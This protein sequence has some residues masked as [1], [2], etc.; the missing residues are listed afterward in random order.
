MSWDNKMMA[1]LGRIDVSESDEEQDDEDEDDAYM[2]D[3]QATQSSLQ[4]N[5]PPQASS[6]RIQEIHEE[7]D[8]QYIY[9][10]LEHT[11]LPRKTGGVRDIFACFF[12]MWEMSY[13]P[14]RKSINKECV[15]M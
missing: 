15:R 10:L 2:V 6:A 8:G 12:Y 14:N 13:I 11:H 1:H 4:A 7:G 5:K 3:E 9:P